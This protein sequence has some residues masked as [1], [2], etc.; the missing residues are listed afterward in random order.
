MET[1]LVILCKTA[2]EKRLAQAFVKEVTGIPPFAW[3]G[4]TF[5]R[6]PNVYVSSTSNCGYQKENEFGKATLSFSEIGKLPSL[7]ELKRKVLFN[8]Q[9]FLM[10]EKQIKRVYA[11][12]KQIV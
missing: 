4:D 12:I 10:T 2:K 3:C 1:D 9:E 6:F 5:E 11:Y 7:T 8:G